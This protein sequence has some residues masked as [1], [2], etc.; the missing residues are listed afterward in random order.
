MRESLL[1]RLFFKIGCG[2]CGQFYDVANV[3]GIG[4]HEDLW[5]LSAFCR[6]CEVQ[7][8]TVVAVEIDGS[9]DVLGDLSEADCDRLAESDAVD[10]DDLLDM[11]RFLK[12]FDGDFAALFSEDQ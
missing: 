10:V 7:G 8:L 3:T 5:F 4:H 9:S 12:E 2:S 1:E 6:A 11:C